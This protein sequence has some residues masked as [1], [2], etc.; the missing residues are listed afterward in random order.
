M[1]YS[2]SILVLFLVFHICLFMKSMDAR[3][4]RN[5][6]AADIFMVICGGR[7]RLPVAREIKSFAKLQCVMPTID[8]LSACS[9]FGIW[10]Q[11]RSQWPRGLRHEQSSPV[12]ILGSCLRIPPEALMFVCIYF[13]FV[14]FCV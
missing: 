11:G 13:V 3:L 12:Q 10:L 6:V 2:F 7:K 1:Q 4:A 9:T 14:L 5:L 8:A